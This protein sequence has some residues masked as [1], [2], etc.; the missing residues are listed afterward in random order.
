[1]WLLQIYLFESMVD[2]NHPIPSKELWPLL[3]N[4][5]LEIVLTGRALLSKRIQIT[6]G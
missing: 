5:N 1:M 6:N 2:I 4:F 3:F